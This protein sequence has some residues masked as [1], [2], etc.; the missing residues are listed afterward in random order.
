MAWVGLLAAKTRESKQF[1]GNAFVPIFRYNIELICSRAFL[2]PRKF[3]LFEDIV[4]GGADVTE[5]T[6]KLLDDADVL[7]ALPGGVGTLT[8]VCRL[9]TRA[10]LDSPARPPEPPR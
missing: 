2:W 8:S 7:V 5:R 3:E 1:V 6:R 9:G 4:V 10:L